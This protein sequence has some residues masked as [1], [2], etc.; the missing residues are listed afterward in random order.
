MKLHNLKNTLG[1]RR[2][3]KRLGRGESSGTGKTSGRGHKGQWARKGHKFKEGF[4]GGQM[5][6]IRRIPK[7][8]FK[9][10][11][12]CSYF[13]VNVDSLNVLPD[14]AEVTLDLLRKTGLVKGG[15]GLRIKVLGRGELQ[16]KLTVR[17]HAF[18]ESARKIIQSA[19]GVCEVVSN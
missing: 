6:F 16:K 3:R 10:P 9:N 7:R 14:G 15:A 1:A 12:R 2:D 19:G 11:V 13:A 4:E 8:G 5:R 17:A 18:S